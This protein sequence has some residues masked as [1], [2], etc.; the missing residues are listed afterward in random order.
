MM[1]DK[2][3]KKATK[4]DLTILDKEL[5]IKAIPWFHEEK[6]KEQEKGKSIWLIA[7]EN[8]HPIGHIQVR[9]DGSKIKKV[10]SNLKN[11]PHIE[12]LGVKENYRKKGVGTKLMDYAENLVKKKGYKKVGLAVEKDNIF[13]EK[14]YSKRGYKNWGKEFV[15]D[16]WN[17]LNKK[18]NK[19]KVNEK[20]NYFIKEI[21]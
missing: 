1:E 8:N 18:E 12:S 17:V 3:I 21:K 15:T 11:C 5:S 14:L 9:F 13:L 10:K 2:E 20:C 16:S 7:W 4:K 6:L 19:Q